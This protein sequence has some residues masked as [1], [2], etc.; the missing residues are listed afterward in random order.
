MVPILR[1]FYPLYI[2]CLGGQ[3]QTGLVGP[4]SV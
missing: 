4:V 3:G 2:H 1:A